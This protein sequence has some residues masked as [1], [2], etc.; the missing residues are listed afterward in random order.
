MVS[1]IPITNQDGVAWKIIYKMKLW[2]VQKKK[3]KKLIRF[4]FLCGKMDVAS[5]FETIFPSKTLWKLNKIDSV[6]FIVFCSFVFT[7]HCLW[8]CHGN[9][10]VIYLYSP[11]YNNVPF[12]TVQQRKYQVK[13]LPPSNDQVRSASVFQ[14]AHVQS[15]VCPHTVIVLMRNVQFVIKISVFLVCYFF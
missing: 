4:P 12:L 2:P 7:G 10:R 6:G 3:K 8:L 1:D 14:T 5:C 9:G 11:F 13:P 15:H